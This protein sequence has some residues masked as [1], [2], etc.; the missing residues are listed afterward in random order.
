[1]LTQIIIKKNLTFF[2]QNIRMSASII[3]FNNNK[4]LKS[5]FYNKNKMIFNISDI[6]INKTLVPK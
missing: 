1:M 4:I 6:D 3:N 5:D 2:S